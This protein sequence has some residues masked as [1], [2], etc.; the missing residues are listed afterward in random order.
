MSPADASLPPWVRTLSIWVA[1]GF[2]VWGLGHAFGGSGQHALEGQ[3]APPLSVQLV[4]G[5]HFDLGAQEGVT[6]VNFWAS[7]CPPCRAEAPALQAVYESGRANFV[8]VAMDRRSVPDA[9][10]LGIGFP[11]AVVTPELQQAFQV[12]SLPSTFV[13][14]SDGMIRASFVGGITQAQLEEAIEEA[15]AY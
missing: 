4:D 11:L 10:R 7:W 1:V 2:V 9:P 5:T 13:V 8:G 6:V 12:Q 14:S 15:S 3:A